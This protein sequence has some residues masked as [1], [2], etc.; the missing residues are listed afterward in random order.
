MTLLHVGK[1]ETSF[2]GIV[3]NG[4][5]CIQWPIFYTYGLGIHG[6]DAFVSLA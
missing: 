3:L 1:Y 2:T 6:L 4:K 5:M